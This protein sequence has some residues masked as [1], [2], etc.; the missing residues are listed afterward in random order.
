MVRERLGTPGLGCSV[1]RGKPVTNL[2]HQGGRRVFWVRP[3]VFK[4]CPIVLNYAQH[5]FT[6]GA[7][8]FLV[9]GLDRGRG[10]L[11]TH[12]IK[13]LKHVDKSL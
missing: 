5:I 4:P 8:R 13:L 3:K 1:D 2:G 9:T 6:E 7:K 10:G 11:Q 12:C